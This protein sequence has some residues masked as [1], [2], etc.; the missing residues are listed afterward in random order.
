MLEHKGVSAQDRIPRLVLWELW[1]VKVFQARNR[2]LQSQL[3]DSAFL[4]HHV[5][6]L[7]SAL[8]FVC[9]MAI[10]TGSLGPFALGCCWDGRG[11]HPHNPRKLQKIPLA[12]LKGHS[13]PGPGRSSGGGDGCCIVT[14]KQWHLLPPP[15]P[16]WWQLSTGFCFHITSTQAECCCPSCTL[17]LR[18]PRGSGQLQR[19]PVFNKD[20]KVQK[21]KTKKIFW[22]RSG[23]SC[24]ISPLFK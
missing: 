19:Q 24:P 22:V 16:S 21:T 4:Y 2:L 14:G 9:D 15:K 10:H 12:G 11:A 7:C 8:G 18:T 1:E 20:R 17:F 6:S 23:L 5:G 3:L 13:P